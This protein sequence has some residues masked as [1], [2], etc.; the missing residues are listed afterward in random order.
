MNGKDTRSL[1]RSAGIST[2]LS[3]ELP[4]GGCPLYH[5]VAPAVTK[6][7]SKFHATASLEIELHGH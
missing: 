7:S 5:R 2:L 6:T 3:C 1:R 4:A